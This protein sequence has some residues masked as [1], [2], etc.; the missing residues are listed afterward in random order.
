MPPNKTF[1][2]GRFFY[3]VI[4][5]LSVPKNVKNCFMKTC[6]CHAK[7]ATLPRKTFSTAT[8][9]LC[10]CHADSFATATL[11]LHSW[12]L[13]HQT[14]ITATINLYCHAES[15]TTAPHNSGQL[16][17][18]TYIW[19]IIMSTYCSDIL[20][21]MYINIYIYVYILLFIYSLQLLQNL[22]HPMAMTKLNDQ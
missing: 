13:P 10:Y 11:N 16:W 9:H 15:L 12:L 2:I 17:K 8:L 5:P 20:L 6:C 18:Y 4:G 21:S 19:T 7:T 1:K 3:Q 14:F 22:P